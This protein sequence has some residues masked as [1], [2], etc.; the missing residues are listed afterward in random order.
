[1]SG[2]SDLLRH[3]MEKVRAEMELVRLETGAKLES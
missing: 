1:M 2:E 3:Q